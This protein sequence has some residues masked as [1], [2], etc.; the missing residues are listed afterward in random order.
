MWDG[1]LRALCPPRDVRR[2]AGSGGAEL[3]LALLGRAGLGCRDPPVVSRGLRS[4]VADEVSGVG[5]EA[6]ASAPVT[7][8]RG[9]ACAAGVRR[10]RSVSPWVS[11]EASE[12]FFFFL[13]LL[14]Q[15]I[16]QCCSS[17]LALMKL[18]RANN[19]SE[20]VWD[21]FFFSF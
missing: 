9:P 2:R 1:E 21:F 5:G 20:Y 13:N 15:T 17:V 10:W 4:R 6:A 11:S 7:A 19:T 14:A 16:K 12:W 8:G 3:P 18:S